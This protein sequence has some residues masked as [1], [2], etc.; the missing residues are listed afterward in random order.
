MPTD[1]LSARAIGDSASDRADA[2]QLALLGLGHAVTDSYGQSLLAPLF[3]IL[4]QRLQLDYAQVGTLPLVMGLSASLGQPLF[5]VITDRWPRI[6]AVALGPAL[7]AI[8][9]GMVGRAGSFAELA[10]LLFLAGLGIGAYHPQ[11]AS[12]ARDAARGRGLAMAAFTVGGN[13]GF[14]LAPILGALYFAW[15]GWER[16]HWAAA[17]GVLLGIAMLAGRGGRAWRAGE[18]ADRPP[19]HG[20]GDPWALT[21][22]TGTVVLRS[23]VQIA[24]VTFLAFLLQQRLPGSGMRAHGVAVTAFLLASA[25]AGPTGGYF[26]DRFGRKRVMV[27]SLATAPFLLQLGLLLP[28]YGIVLG[29]ALGGYVLMLPHPA[30][31]IMAQEYLPRS[32]GVGAS[33]IT[34]LAWGLAQLLQRPLGELAD[35]AGIALALQVVCWLPLLGI[36]MA[37]PLSDRAP[38]PL[39]PVREAP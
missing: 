31:V 17:P 18:P 28:G 6:P 2:R 38:K 13:L 3:P 9:I 24:V 15:F 12:L 39:A 8:F 33:L 25:L 37:W 36:P 4:A 11:G 16:F 32:A 5:G 27:A 34:G 10:M 23:S 29:L 19:D 7:A 21:L 1:D 30:N 22:L 14:G 26:C 35:H 20:R